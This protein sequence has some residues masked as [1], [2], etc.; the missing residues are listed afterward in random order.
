[1]PLFRAGGQEGIATVSI[2]GREGTMTERERE[3][4]ILA[5][6]EE[7]KLRRNRQLEEW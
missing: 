7:I 1:M 3:R 2:N 5:R 4:E 6:V